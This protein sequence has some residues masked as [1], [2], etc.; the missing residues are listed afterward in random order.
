M[1]F[2]FLFFHSERFLWPGLYSS[3]SLWNLHVRVVLDIGLESIY[4]RCDLRKQKLVLDRGIQFLDRTNCHFLL[5]NVYLFFHLYLAL[6]INICIIF[7]KSCR[8]RPNLFS[9][10]IR[11]PEKSRVYIIQL[12]II[13]ILMN[14]FLI[15][16]TIMIY[17]PSFKCSALIRRQI[18]KILFV[19]LFVSLPRWKRSHLQWNSRS[20]W[21]F[22]VHAFRIWR[23]I[24]LML[25]FVF[26]SYWV[27]D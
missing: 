8:D 15:T 14:Q 13:W 26:K 2:S 25:S 18:Q 23:N 16:L 4:Q 27:L 12:I 21:F 7:I 20:I 17:K 5:S 9:D 22:Q 1:A 19:A 6:S 11:R 10:N 24:T 3:I